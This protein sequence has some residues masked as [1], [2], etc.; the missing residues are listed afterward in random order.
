M[1]YG[2]GFRFKDVAAALLLSCF[3]AGVVTASD[4]SRDRQ[5]RRAD[6][7]GQSDHQ[8]RPVAGGAGY[9]AEAA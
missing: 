8:G 7:L 1:W 6:R 3:I 9:Q 5:Q 2:S 4:E